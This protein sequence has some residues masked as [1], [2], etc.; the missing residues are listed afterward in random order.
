MFIASALRLL[1][2]LRETIQREKMDEGVAGHFPRLRKAKRCDTPNKYIN[3][4][5]KGLPKTSPRKCGTS[6]I[7]FNFLIFIFVFLYFLSIASNL[8]PDFLRWHFLSVLNSVFRDLSVTS[9][10]IIYRFGGA[11]LTGIHTPAVC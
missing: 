7:V 9:I 1:P 11:S 2:K 3:D 8:C 4:Q 6:I 5:N 10:Y